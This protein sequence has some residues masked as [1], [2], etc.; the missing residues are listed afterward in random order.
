MKIQVSIKNI[1]GTEKIYPVCDQAKIFTKL[2]KQ[3]T[4]TREDVSKIKQLGFE[5]EV[6]QPEVKL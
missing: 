1:Y 2:V 4:L 6:V 5:I 3:V